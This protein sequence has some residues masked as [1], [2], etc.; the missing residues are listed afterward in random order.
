[1]H[2][3]SVMPASSNPFFLIKKDSA[4]YTQNISK[5]QVFF[6]RKAVRMNCAPDSNIENATQTELNRELFDT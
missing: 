5:P 1:M 6:M 2:V 4:I 3:S